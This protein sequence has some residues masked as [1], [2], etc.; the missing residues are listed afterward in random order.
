MTDCFVGRS[1]RRYRVE[2][3]RPAPLGASPVGGAVQFAVVSRH[4]D[5]MSLLLFE[6]ADDTSPDVEIPFDRETNRIGD[7]WYCRVHGCHAGAFYL[8]RAS[9]PYD[10][11][12][13]QRF[14]ARLGLL[15]PY[16]RALTVSETIGYSLGYDPESPR[17]DLE[18]ARVDNL[19]DIPK[20][21][22]VDEQ[23]DWQG[24]KPLRYPLQ[25]CVIYEAHVRGL[26]QHPSSGVEH[27]GTYKGVVEMIPR[28]RE[29]GI[30]SLELL[31][32]HEFDPNENLRSNPETG[33]QLKNYW[34]YNTIAFFAPSTR[35]ASDSRPGAVVEEFRYM[36]RELHKAGIEIILDVVFNHTGEGNETGPTLSFR[37]LDNSLYYQ[38]D[39][40]RRFYRNY[41]G[42]GNTLN[43]NAPVLRN[44]ILD[45][46]R[47]WVVDMHIDGF[48]FDLASILGRDQHGALMENPPLLEQIAEDPIL[49]DTKIIAEAWDAGGAYQVGRFPGTRWAEWNDRYR[50]DVRRFWRGDPNLTGA[51]ATRLSGSADLYRASGRK[52]F[53]SINFITSHD[54]FTL[55]DLVSYSRKHNEMNGEGGRDGHSLEHSYNY[56]AEGETLVP[57]VAR[58]RSRQVRNML[59][60]MFL[61]LGT[62]MLSAGD[63]MRR[64]QRGNNNAYCQDNEVSWIDHRLRSRHADLVRFVSELIRFRRSQPIL[65]RDEFFNG[66]D[67]SGS[68]LADVSWLDAEGRPVEWQVADGCLCVLIDGTE[69]EVDGVASDDLFFVFNATTIERDVRMPAPNRRWLRVL[70][71]AAD[72]PD[73]IFP[74]GSRPEFLG[75]TCH[76]PAR[77]T[78]VFVDPV[79]R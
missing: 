68:T 12:S 56:G 60:T 27:P 62:P 28:F 73:D 23:F 2:P 74:A 29:L 24:D 67:T 75:A 52:P 20:C 50:D 53:H 14:N 22:V 41:S 31:P 45:C 71:T 36:V 54:G 42:C 32:V 7:V 79:R 8:Y 13:G 19:D 21:I 34:G 48:R 6:H 40:D 16:A 47:Y 63:E 33:E 55:N 3:G 25:D 43:C 69:L 58:V 35:Y 1:G 77:S 64:T 72:P 66:Y 65:L 39:D 46:L 15:D 26:T 4:A 38:L 30:T 76:V 10:P 49:R 18:P 61:S 9:G 17:R 11:E 57:A 44:L 5:A 51:F 70:D 78:T 37:G 59:V